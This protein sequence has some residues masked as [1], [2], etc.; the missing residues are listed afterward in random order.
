MQT[1]YPSPEWDDFCD[2]SDI[3]TPKRINEGT[4]CTEDAQ[5]C[6]DGSFVGRDPLNNC[7]F[8]P[9]ENEFEK[10]DNE[11]DTAN[12]AYT[13]TLFI[14]TL[15]LGILLLLLGGKL[16][17][18]EAVG[19]GIMGG[20]VITIFYGSVRYWEY[21]GDMFRFIL[22]IIALIAVIYLAY[23]LNKHAHKKKKKFSLNFG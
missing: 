6:P 16:F 14:I 21:A 5:Q 10:C 2:E 15:I 12:E 17:N 11:F 13:K 9:C 22:S 23:W 19:A 7:E 20:G 1:F 8:F 4:V 18:L 3:R